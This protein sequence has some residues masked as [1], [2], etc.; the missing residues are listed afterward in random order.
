MRLFN[1][2]FVVLAVAF[3]SSGAAVSKADDI[4]V[5]NV[6]VVH[7]SY[8]LAG[9]DK[10]FLRSHKRTDDEGKL[11][12]HDKEERTGENL[13]GAL[14]LQR[15]QQDTNVRFTMFGK[16]KSAGYVKDNFKEHIP[17]S[18]YKLYKAYRRMYG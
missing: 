15:M 10:R 7:S 8:V 5:P 9:E 11:P 2:T 6:D 18:L 13:L 14:T 17:K 4:S 16:W 1:T 3:L 12:K